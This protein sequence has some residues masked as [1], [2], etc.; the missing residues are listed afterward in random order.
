MIIQI[1]KR[2]LKEFSYL[3][4]IGFPLIFGY[5]IP[6]ITGHPFRTWP[7]W[8]SIPILLSGVFAPTKLQILYISWINVGNVLGWINS[9]IILGLIFL[10]VLQPIALIMRIF[11][12]DPLRKKKNPFLS[13]KEV[14]KNS[15]VDLTRIF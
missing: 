7:L 15:K 4:G 3:I 1:P 13:Y 10:L 2:K 12:Y 14:K 9:K 6:L 8:I 11:R 5:I